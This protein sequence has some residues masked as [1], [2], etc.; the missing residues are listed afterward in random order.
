MLPELRAKRTKG[1]EQCCCVQL[2]R[3][4][5]DLLVFAPKDAPL[6]TLCQFGNVGKDGLDQL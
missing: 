3:L 5:K 6:M 4:T 1:E 2:Q